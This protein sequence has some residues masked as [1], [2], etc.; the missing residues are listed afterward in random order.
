MRTVNSNSH[1]EEEPE[2]GERIVLSPNGA[3]PEHPLA[4]GK[5]EDKHRT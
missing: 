4:S 2:A 1:Y 5:C 3:V